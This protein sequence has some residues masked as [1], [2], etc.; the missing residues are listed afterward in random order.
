MVNWPRAAGVLLHISS[1]PS[2]LGNG[3]FGPAA[4]DFVNFL[5]AARQRYWQVLPLVPAAQGDSPYT[6]FSAFAGNAWFISP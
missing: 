3:D 6:S 5:H 2:P 4:Y 1:L